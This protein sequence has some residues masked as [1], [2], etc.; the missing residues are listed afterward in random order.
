[1]WNSESLLNLFIF[2]YPSNGVVLFPSLNCNYSTPDVGGTSLL[3]WLSEQPLHVCTYFCDF[4]NHP[5]SD[6]LPQV[7]GCQLEHFLRKTR[8]ARGLNLRTP[9]R[10]I[11]RKKQ[12]TAGLKPA[13]FSAAV[14]NFEPS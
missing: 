10:N 11:L 4:K 13:T 8:G 3:P 6:L 2:F 14:A 5:P 9:W 7:D 1:M 12:G